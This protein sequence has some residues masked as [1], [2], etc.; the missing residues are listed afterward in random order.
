M[1]HGFGRDGNHSA[2]LKDGVVLWMHAWL[3]GDFDV[4][5]ELGGEV[6]HELVSLELFGDGLMDFDLIALARVGLAFHA[7]DVAADA[8]G[9]GLGR[10]DAAAAVADGALAVD[11]AV[12][13]LA[14]LLARDLDEPEVRDVDDIRLRAVVLD[15]PAHVGEQLFFLRLFLHVDE[16]DD[17]DA[18]DVAQ[19]NL[20]ED[21]GSGLEVRLV[22]SVAEIRLADVLAR[23][24]VNDGQSFP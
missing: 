22:D 5:A 2:L 24:D 15:L 3:D 1:E 6:H 18:A 10:L 16:V 14:R 20:L 19:A 12:D 7:A 9:D 17:D 23:V 21:L 8:D 11:D 13:V 4:S